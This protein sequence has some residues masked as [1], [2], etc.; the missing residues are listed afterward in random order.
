[1]NTAAGMGIENA[2]IEK[3]RD[4]INK[5]LG[6]AP[7]DVQEPVTADDWINQGIEELKKDKKKA[8]AHFRKAIEINPLNS[9]AYIFAAYVTDALEDYP[10]TIKLLDEAIKTDPKS[11][12]AWVGRAMVHTILGNEKAAISDMQNALSVNLSQEVMFQAARMYGRLS[13]KNAQ[14][15]QETM[16]YLSIVIRSGYGVDVAEKSDDFSEVKELPE[17]KRVISEAKAQIVPKKD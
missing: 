6:L 15:K 2:R 4:K 10:E 1:L 12:R 16:A 13:K 8:L 5:A 11:Y 9:N 3:E 7:K 17:F 14:Y